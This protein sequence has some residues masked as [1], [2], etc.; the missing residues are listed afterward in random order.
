MTTIVAS[1]KHRTMVADRKVTDTAASMRYHTKKLR[2]IGSSIVGCAG[3]S[4]AISKFVRWLE[5]GAPQDDRPKFDRDAT[6]AAL[7][8]N[9]KG[10][11]IFDPSG[12]YSI[13]L[14]APN[15]PRIASNSR[16]TATAE[17]SK[18]IVTGMLA[19]YGT[20]KVNEADGTFT[21]L[22]EG[23]SF[24]NW[25]GV[26]QPARKFA[27]RGDKLTILNPAPSAGGGVN[28]LTLKRL[29]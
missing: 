4:S 10:L 2:A 29:K 19:H 7:L 26:E 24:P 18:A 27:V 3:D 5:A 12:R 28:E 9:E 11:F 14:Y 15:L 25:T 8:L 16:T 6:L 20:Y 23:S 1:K 21:V 17:E 22:P 13:Q